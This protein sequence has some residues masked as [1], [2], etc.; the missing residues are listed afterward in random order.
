MSL[1]YQEAANAAVVLDYGEAGQA[2]VAGLNTLKLPG[3]QRTIIE[4]KEFRQTSRQFAGSASRTNLEFGGNAVFNDP[5]QRLLKTYYEANSKFGPVGDAVGECRVYLNGTS[6]TMLSSDFLALDTANDSEAVFQ[7]TA[8]DFPS[9]DVDGMFPFSSGLTV[10]G[11]YA[12]FSVHK[13]ASTIAFVDSNPD[14]ITDSGSGFVTA[15]FEDGMTLIVEGTV[16]NDGIYIID[17]VVAGTIT[18]TTAM[19]L[20]AESAGSSFTLH[21]GF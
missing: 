2:V 15:G 11:R 12:I 17:T 8:Y 9:A 20:S 6:A 3:G 5:G 10:G 19:S 18:L 7:V 16:S 1:S 21:G 14:T 4:V 13:T